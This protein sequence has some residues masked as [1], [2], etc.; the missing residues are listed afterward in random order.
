M[1]RTQTTLAAEQLD[2]RTLP[3]AGVMDL[4]AHGAAAAADTFIARQTDAQPTGTGF[5]N[6]FVRVQGAASGGGSEQGYN[7]TAR[8]LQ[9]DENKS[10][11]FTRGLT[12][13]Q[14]PVVTVNGVAYR[15]F[16]LDINQK[17]SD[18]KLSV[19][20]VRIFLGG[21]SNL[22]GY[23][24]TA[25]TL[26]GKA[27][28]F[29]LDAGGDVS[30]LL[31]ARLNSGS[32]SGDMFLLVRNDAF[33]GAD[34]GTFVYLYS[35]MGGTAGATANGGF[36]EWAVRSVPQNQTAGTSSLSGYVFVDANGNGVI[37]AGERALAGV[38]VQL[39]GVD[40]LGQTV[41]W[42]T[43][44]DTNGYYEFTGLRAGTY[45]ILETQPGGFADGKDYVGTINGAQVGQ[46][47]NDRLFDIFLG[48]SQKGT[49]YNFTELFSE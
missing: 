43:T 49:N 18:S 19:D 21:T 8:P 24:T 10:P 17:S 30:I 4:T 27:A 12:L 37:D 35:K 31:D 13:G 22:T 15:E 39:Q 33:A 44:T 14:V 41:V 46:L 34:P 38:M 16:L 7:T 23:D 25:K 36:E 29:D 40:D 11:Q 45:S 1:A 47:D 26:A 32:G 9:F 28:V 6:S 48:A 5:I 42:T 2:E 20:E 3:S